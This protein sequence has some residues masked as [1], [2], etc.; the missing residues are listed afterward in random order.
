MLKRTAL[1]SFFLILSFLF[2]IEQSQGNTPKLKTVFIKKVQK[3]ELFNTL[4]YPTKV[5]AKKSSRLL[6]ETEGVI[7]QIK[8]NLGDKVS[9]GTP[10]LVIKN[11]DPTYHFRPMQLLA[12]IDG[13]IAEIH[14]TQGSMVN[15]GKLLL[16]ITDPNEYQMKFHVTSTD[17]KYLKKGMTGTFLPNSFGEKPKPLKVSVLGIS[18]LISPTTGTAQ[19][20]LSLA[21]DA[22]ESHPAIGSM[23]NVKFK[24][25]NHKGIM[26]REDAVFYYGKKTFVYL[27]KDEKVKKIE[28]TL[29]QKLLGQIEVLSGLNVGETLIEKYSE[30]LKD[31]EKVQVAQNKKGS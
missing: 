7:E 9:K 6:A 15:K 13:V 31:G 24:V 21:Q 29:G 18:P 27:L 20:E 17:L 14:E 3:K 11:T 28:V 16:T 2:F 10:L 8:V 19:A 22:I 5:L 25:N 23:G 4:A 12:P 30:H 26:I 1:L